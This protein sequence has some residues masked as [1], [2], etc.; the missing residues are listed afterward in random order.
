MGFLWFFLIGAEGFL[1]GRTD[2]H[3]ILGREGKA[4]YRFDP[5]FK[6]SI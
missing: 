5:V 1:T 6:I 3:R 2:G 4:S